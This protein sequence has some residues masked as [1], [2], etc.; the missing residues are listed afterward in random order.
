MP[1]TTVIPAANGLPELTFD[2]SAVLDAAPYFIGMTPGQ[3]A[4]MCDTHGDV[5]KVDALLVAGLVGGGIEYKT[6]RGYVHKMRHNV[7][8]ADTMDSL[9]RQVV[10]AAL[11]PS[12]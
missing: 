9:L 10:A 12:P 6:A 1:S 4:S 11:A 2:L 7:P 3:L 8:T 5:L